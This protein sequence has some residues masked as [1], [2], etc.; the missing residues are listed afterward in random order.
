MGVNPW[1]YLLKISHSY[2]YLGISS[3]Y[4]GSFKV[5]QKEL[6]DKG[7]KAMFNLIGKCRKLDSSIDIQTKL[8][9]SLVKPIVLYGAEVWGKQSTYICNQ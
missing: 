4:N 1:G 2:N 3:N 5:A 6:H 7:T 8:F 9:N